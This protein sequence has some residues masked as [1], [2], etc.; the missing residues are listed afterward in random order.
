MEVS[1]YPNG[2]LRSQTAANRRLRDAG[3]GPLRVERF[4]VL[5]VT[6]EDVLEDGTGGVRA[7]GFQKRTSEGGLDGEFMRE[8]AGR[9]PE[10]PHRLPGI[11]LQKDSA[12]SGQEPTDRCIVRNGLED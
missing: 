9:S 5:A 4:A 3:H 12:D 11:V 2:I 1:L 6:S 7:S 8:P 10:L